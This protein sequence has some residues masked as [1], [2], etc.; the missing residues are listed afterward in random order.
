[1]SRRVTVVGARGFI[2]G[3]VAARARRLG[4]EV[5]ECSHDAVPLGRD[6][7]SIVY[8]SGIAWDA[9][10]RPLESYELHASAVV[11]LLARARYERLVYLSSTRVYDRAGATVE[12]TAPALRPD[13]ADDTYALSKLAGEGAVLAAKAENRVIRCSN[14]YGESFRSGLFLSDVLRQA[15]TTGRIAI[16]TSLDSSKDY[17]SVDDVAD[18]ALRVASE[19]RERVYNVAAGKNTTHRALLEVILQAVPARVVVAPGAPTVTVPEI[20]AGRVRSEFGFL[21]R[22]VLADLPGVARAF[23]LNLGPASVDGGR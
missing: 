10:L 13:V 11:R 8:A 21:A 7:G 3:R 1:M 2:G 20:D 9:Q 18:L 16:R 19:S 6:L 23:L 22:D 4:Y 5:L 12:E 14:V 17:V 15:A